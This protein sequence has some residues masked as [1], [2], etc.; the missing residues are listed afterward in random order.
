M[1]PPLCRVFF[2]SGKCIGRRERFNTSRSFGETYGK[3]F[4]FLKCLRRLHQPFLCWKRHNGSTNQCSFDANI[5]VTL[6]TVTLAFCC[7]PEGCHIRFMCDTCRPGDAWNKQCALLCPAGWSEQD[8]FSPLS[9]VNS[10][11]IPVC[12]DQFPL[13]TSSVGAVK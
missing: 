3:F 5:N 9:S 2:T 6:S 8:S 7:A 13:T 4:S 1:S 10:A 11:D 12:R